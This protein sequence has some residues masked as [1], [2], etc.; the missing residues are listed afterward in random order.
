MA[1]RVHAQG[2]HHDTLLPQ[3]QDL[4]GRGMTIADA[5]GRIAVSGATCPAGGGRSFAISA[6]G[7]GLRFGPA[8]MRVG[9]PTVSGHSLHARPLG[10]A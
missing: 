1:K 5:V 9:L 2:D 8:T 6:C 7:Y 4:Y 10:P 3:V